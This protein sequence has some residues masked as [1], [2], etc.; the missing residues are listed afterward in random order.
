MFICPRNGEK[1]VMTDYDRLL[2]LSCSWSAEQ[3]QVTIEGDKIIIR[4][5]DNLEAL[6]KG[7]KQRRPSCNKVQL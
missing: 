1:Q 2:C 6:P 3:D 4:D 5:S 7:T